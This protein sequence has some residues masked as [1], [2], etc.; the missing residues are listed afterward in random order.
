[1]ESPKG[2]GAQ[3]EEF[4]VDCKVA[5]VVDGFKDGVFEEKTVVK[6]L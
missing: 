6:L 1:M 3:T 5:V 4:C 2:N